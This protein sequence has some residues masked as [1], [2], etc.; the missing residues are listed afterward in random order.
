MARARQ[1]QDLFE[2]ERSFRLL[3]EGVA[4]YAIY[5]LDPAGIVT[6]WNIG[7]QRI[8]GYLPE[9][10]VGQHFSRFYTPTDQANGKPARAL[11]IAR[12]QG[13]YEEEG[14]RV[15]KDGSFFWASIVID[16]IKEGGRLIGF[17]KIT[18]DISE[19]REAALNLE[20]M[21]K[22]L[23]ASQKLDALGQLTGGVAHDFNNLLMVVGGSAQVLKKYAD[24]EK[25]RRAVEALESAARRGAAL[26][27]QLLTFARRQNVNPQTVRLS[28]RIDAVRD[29]LKTGVGGNVQ[30]ITDVEADLWPIKVDIAELETALVNLVINARD[31]MPDGGEIR[32]IAANAA[33]DDEA[34][35]GDFV[36]IRV[37]DTGAGIPPDIVAKVFDPFFTTKPVGK[38]TGLGLSQV[39][40]FAYQAGGLVD[41]ASE[42]GEGTTVTIFLPRDNTGIVSDNRPS[43]AA[44][45]SGTILLVEDNPDVATASTG[46]LEQL[47]YAVRWVSNAEAALAEIDGN[48]IDLVFSDIV[49]PGKM[50][51]L[52]LAQAIRGKYPRMPILLATGYSDTLRRTSLGFQIIRKPYEIH[53]LSQALSKVSAAAA[54]T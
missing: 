45:G 10:I 38:G 41:L 36:A 26:T 20:R 54:R 49:M 40:G 2:S 28:E 43:A 33:L 35:K 17:A 30:L 5:M 31:A 16:P 6:N 1:E 53:E 24:D 52:G 44:S 32:I 34:H 21:Q 51:G 22:Q 3:V 8:K 4:D 48:R 27:S 11:K 42:L 46:L 12:E 25:S 18:R 7:G 47:G 23:A 14:W 15:R 9:E 50:D 29:V 37:S 39:H 13:R 19:R